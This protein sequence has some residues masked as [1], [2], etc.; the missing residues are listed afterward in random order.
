MIRLLG[1]QA[2]SLLL[3]PGS[4]GTLP[5]NPPLTWRHVARD[6]RIARASLPKNAIIRFA[7]RLVALAGG[8]HESATVQH[9]DITPAV[10]NQS[11]LLQ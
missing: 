4:V 6:L 5:N 11:A 3:P 9:S 8:R 1:P 7:I 2:F 10:V